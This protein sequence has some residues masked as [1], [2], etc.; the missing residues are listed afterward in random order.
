[1]LQE[2]DSTQENLI[3]IM[4]NS[5]EPEEEASQRNIKSLLEEASKL[6]EGKQKP[7]RSKSD[8]EN[9]EKMKDAKKRREQVQQAKEAQK[10]KPFTSEPLP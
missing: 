2:V 6:A 7:T 8:Q 1:M 4:N 10:K 3:S 9:T 5:A